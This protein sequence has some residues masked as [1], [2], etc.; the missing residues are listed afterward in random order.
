MTAAGPSLRLLIDNAL[1]PRLAEAL[2]AG[3]LDAVH[4]RDYG[5]AAAPDAVIL[6][7]AEAESRLVLTADA[8]DFGEQLAR[9]GRRRPSVVILR[10]PFQRRVEDRL[11][12]ILATLSSTQEALREGAIVSI[13]PR[14][15]RIRRLPLT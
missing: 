1:S 3:G 5:I 10:E 7:R 13:G 12:L 14:G 4:V 2:R 8:G 9:A 15:V 11:S 6:E